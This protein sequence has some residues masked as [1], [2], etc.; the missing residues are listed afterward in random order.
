MPGES[1]GW[2][3][4]LS[5]G[6]TGTAVGSFTEAHEIISESL[7]KT[8]TILDTNGIRGTRSHASERTAAGT[9]TIAGQIVYEISPLILDLMLPRILGA[10]ASGT[11]FALADT[12]PEFD[13]LIDRGASRFIYGNCTVN[14]ATFTGASGG[15]I[16]M[17]LDITGKTETLSATAFPTITAPVDPPYVF[18]QGV[19]TL[20]G[21]ARSFASFETTIDN[22]L[23]AKF[24]NSQSATNIN[25]TDR[26][27]SFKCETPYTSSEADLY[28][29]ALLGSAASL[30]ITNGN[31]S[32]TF[33]YGKLQ[34]PDMSPVIPGKGEIPLMLDGIARMTSTTRE[35]V[36]TNDSTA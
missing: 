10:N 20:V 5:M 21:S 25:P 8:G 9:Y 34:F 29:Q 32:L 4:R 6:A 31:R 2:A 36:V 33:T 19:L 35:L 1:M 11:T 13:V 14:K 16:R 30:A 24:Y 23:S 28:N 7:K 27:V 12:L 22:V 26:I 3:S 17:T 15:L 18:H